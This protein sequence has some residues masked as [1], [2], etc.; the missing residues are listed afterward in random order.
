MPEPAQV[1]HISNVPLLGRL[2]ALTTLEGSSW[3]NTLAY[4]HPS[5]ITVVKRFY[6]IFFSSVKVIQGL[7]KAKLE[8]KKQHFSFNKTV[9]KAIMELHFIFE[10]NDKI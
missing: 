3:T 4:Y 10:Y 6:N 7:L 9:V 8:L 5:Q 2:L 1:K